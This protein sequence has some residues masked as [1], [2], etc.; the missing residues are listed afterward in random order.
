MALF[1]RSVALALQGRPAEAVEVLARCEAESPLNS[2]QQRHYAV[3]L[4]R[5]GRYEAASARL[6]AALSLDPASKPECVALEQYFAYSRRF[7]YEQ[8][9]ARTRALLDHHAFRGPKEVA[10]DVLAA[11]RE[12]RGY[13]MIRLNDGEGAIMPLSVSDEAEFVEAYRRNRK[14]FHRWWFGHEAID[15][16]DWL[17]A[18]AEL[19]RV[20]ANADCLGGYNIAHLEVRHRQGD[21]QMQ[22]SLF[23]IVRKLEQI[24]ERDP[25]RARAITLTDPVINRFMLNDG[26]L[27]R[28]LHAQERIGLVSW[29]PDLPAALAKRFGLKEVFFHRTTGEGAIM[30]GVEPEP[31]GEFHRRLKTELANARPGVLYLV[32]AGVPGKIC[33]ELIKRAGGVALDIGTVVDIWMKAPIRPFDP[34][35]EQHMLVP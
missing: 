10:D 22:S 9:H 14:Y 11:L 32:G 27:E 34:G 21:F 12:G 17:A 4:A 29:N 3:Q 8:A 30:G 24:R 19:G 20:I 28:V 26:E 18:S 7:P 31:F 1:E 16:P 5:A 25:E 33:C 15:E 6:E 35:A 2:F 13:C 23:N